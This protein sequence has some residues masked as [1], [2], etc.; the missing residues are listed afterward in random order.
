V[1]I[2]LHGTEEEC[3]EGARRLARVFSVVSVSEPYADR[4]QSSLFRVYCEVR[5]DGAPSMPQASPSR[6]GSRRPAGPVTAD[7]EDG[8]LR[9][10]KPVR[11]TAE[12]WEMLPP[13]RRRGRR[14]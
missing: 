8:R 6:A 11:L 4:G 3:R 7:A 2:R 5:M 13:E 12:E 10:R 9:D 1:K 14:A